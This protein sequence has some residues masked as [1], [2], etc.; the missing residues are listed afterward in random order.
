M[1]ACGTTLLRSERAPLGWFNG[2][3]SQMGVPIDDKQTQ[4]VPSKSHTAN[5]TKSKSAVDGG[6]KSW[7]FFGPY[8]SSQHLSAPECGCVSRGHTQTRRPAR[9][10]Y[11][12]LFFTFPLRPARQSTR[13]EKYKRLLPPFA[14]HDR[15]A[16][17]FTA[18]VIQTPLEE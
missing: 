3:H 13:A 1:C 15:C 16:R 5:A 4:I 7:Y 12:F 11:C 17:T 9:E 8:R 2:P 10:Y 18:A 14:V 6:R